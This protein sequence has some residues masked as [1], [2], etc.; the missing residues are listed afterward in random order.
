MLLYICKKD[1]FFY[2]YFIDL[3]LAVLI[4][5]YLQFFDNIKKQF[6]ILVFNKNNFSFKFI[7]V[8]KNL[9]ILLFI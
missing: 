5:N 6:F 3:N 4:K 7:I 9:I 8:N 1:I 2:D